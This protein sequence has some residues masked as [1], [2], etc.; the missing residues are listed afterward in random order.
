MQPTLQVQRTPAR[1]RFPILYT[2]DLTLL[3]LTTLQTTAKRIYN[4]SPCIHNSCCSLNTS[5]PTEIHRNIK[6]EDKKELNGI[7]GLLTDFFIFPGFNSLS[8]IW[9]LGSCKFRKIDIL[10]NKKIYQTINTTDQIHKTSPI[11]SSI[12]TGRLL[13]SYTTLVLIQNIAEYKCKKQ[14]VIEKKSTSELP[15]CTVPCCQPS[16]SCPIL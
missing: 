2:L 5:Q 9:S 6:K 11:T 8:P 4:C 1:S 13:K 12:N 15:V 7:H 16:S 10:R 3:Y 14:R